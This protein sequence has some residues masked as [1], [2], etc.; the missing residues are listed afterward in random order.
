M[1]QLSPLMASLSNSSPNKRLIV[2]LLTLIIG[3]GVGLLFATGNIHLP[4]NALPV[5]QK[6]VAPVTITFVGD[7][8]MDRGVRRSVEQNM[9][10]DYGLLFKNA[11]YLTE[12]DITFANLEGPVA[13]TTTGKN[14][15]SKFSFRMEPKSIGALKGA[16]FDIVSF[17]NNHVGD[18]GQAAFTETLSRLRE[19]GMVAAGA[20]STATDA[21]SVRIISV[22]GMKIGFLAASDVGPQW[23]KA[24]ATTPGILLA[25][26]PKLSTIIS[27]AKKQV[28]VLVVSFHFG[29]EYSP[30]SAR[31]ISLAHKAVDSGADIVVG[32]HPHVMQKIEWYKPFGSAQGK[33]IFYSLGNFIF[34][35]S[36]SPHTL[37][38][39]VARVSIDP[40]TKAIIATEMVSPMTKQFIPQNPIPFTENMLVTKSFTP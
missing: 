14:V 3:G 16:G 22:R 1:N 21:A 32:A 6:K 34:D 28:D 38:G 39:M 8:M 23:M 17:A 12:S 35:Q 33:P 4:S 31:Q 9:Q 7:I 27:D 10:G 2:V 11:S 13:A 24:T 26:D 18:Y 37:R 19:S 30:V 29:N 20:G 5:K 40:K 25:S 36:F 15:G